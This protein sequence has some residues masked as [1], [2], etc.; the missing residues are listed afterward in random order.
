MFVDT[1]FTQAYEHLAKEG[2]TEPGA[3]VTCV[4]GGGLLSGIVHGMK[5]QWDHVPIIA[6]E[7]HGADSF[8]KAVNAGKLVKL[9]KITSHAKTLGN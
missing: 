9:E 3:V 2:Y 8:N 7:T 1:H 5:H 6:M 4:G